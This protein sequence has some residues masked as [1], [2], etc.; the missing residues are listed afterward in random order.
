MK[1]GINKRRVIQNVLWNHRK[2]TIKSKNLLV[3][4]H[5]S[6]TETKLK[7]F[8]IREAIYNNYVKYLYS[9]LSF[10]IME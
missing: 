3:Q 8:R 10:Y 4:S 2:D 1:N 5:T 7:D 9:Y 6:H